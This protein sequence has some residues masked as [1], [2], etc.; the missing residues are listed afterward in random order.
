MEEEKKPLTTWQ[1]YNS[2]TGVL[3]VHV[4]DDP[5]S[6]IYYRGPAEHY[7]GSATREA[8]KEDLGQ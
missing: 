2:K 4:S 7:D 3:T 8:T 1:H 6:D 5:N